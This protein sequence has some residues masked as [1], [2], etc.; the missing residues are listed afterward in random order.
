MGLVFEYPYD[1]GLKK[2]IEE[3]FGH[4]PLLFMIVPFWYGGVGTDG[5]SYYKAATKI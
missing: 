2:N 3:L 5:L 4:H 1:H